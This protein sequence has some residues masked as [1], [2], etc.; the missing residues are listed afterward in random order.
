MEEMKRD[1]MEELEKR[2]SDP[3]FVGHFQDYMDNVIQDF[4]QQ[5]EQVGRLEYAKKATPI[6][7]WHEDEGDC[8]WWRFPIS[9]A[10]YC[11]T[12]LD[13]GFPEYL[14]HY[15]NIVMPRNLYTE[16][17]KHINPSRCEFCGDIL[18]PD[19][20]YHQEKGVCDDGCYSLVR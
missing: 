13:E 2:G 16:G 5:T 14:T 12:P 9:E 20:N 7:E 10:P 18:D 6:E 19:N 11:G 8:L 1:V 3:Y 15:T 17:Q 4:K